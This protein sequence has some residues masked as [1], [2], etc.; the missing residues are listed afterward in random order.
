MNGL[1]WYT[2]NHQSAALSPGGTNISAWKRQIEGPYPMWVMGESFEFLLHVTVEER[3]Q[4]RGQNRSLWYANYLTIV[5]IVNLRY[6]LQ[7]IQKANLKKHSHVQYSPWYVL[8]EVAGPL[9]FWRR[10]RPPDIEQQINDTAKDRLV[11]MVYLV[12][13]NCM[14]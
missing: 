1:L 11:C 4:Q 13:E 2:N 8:R 12:N 14:T 6:R 9:A 10:Y 5:C 3:A 7:C